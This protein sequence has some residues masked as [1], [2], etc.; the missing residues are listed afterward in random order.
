MSELA[1]MVVDLTNEDSPYLDV[2]RPKR[3]D[4]LE[5]VPDGWPWSAA[6]LAARTWRILVVPDLPLHEAKALRVPEPG[7]SILNGMLRY[8]AFYLDMQ[9]EPGPPM[10]VDAETIRAAKRLKAPIPDPNVIG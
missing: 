2:G 7:D 1:V 8:R 4:V 6:E 10:Y 3:G 5:V 9:I